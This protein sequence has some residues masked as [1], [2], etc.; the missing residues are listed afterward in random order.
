MGD[1]EADGQH[2]DRGQGFDGSSAKIG[3]QALT[4]LL[5]GIAVDLFGGDAEVTQGV[6]HGD[7]VIDPR[8]KAE[9]CT[10][11]GAAR[12]DLSGGPLHQIVSHGCTLKLPRDKLATAPVYALGVNLRLGGLR[13]QWRQI[14]LLDQIRDVGLVD[15]LLEHGVL[16]SVEATAIEAVRG[17]CQ[18]KQA[19]IGIDIPQ[20]GK[21]LAVHARC[22]SRNK[23]RLVYERQ[24]EFPQLLD[25]VVNRLDAAE[26]DRVRG[27]P[28]THAGRENA[29]RCLRPDTD[30]FGVVLLDQ[31]LAMRDHAHPHQRIVVQ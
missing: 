29:C 27:I 9:P 3:D 16:A 10:P 26:D 6:T 7:G 23:V 11:I 14:P 24:I 28:P 31:F 19:H 15:D 4:L 20:I 30:Q 17:S 13:H 2:I 22:L 21:K 8:A 18:P 1:V 12:H 25:L 5:R